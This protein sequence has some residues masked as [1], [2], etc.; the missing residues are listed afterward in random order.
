MKIIKKILSL[1]VVFALAFGAV[2]L[3]PSASYANALQDGAC[4]GINTVLQTPGAECGDDGTS[5]E[6]ISSTI[7]NVIN[8]FSL[9]VGA[10][11][12]IMIIYGGF[13]YITS[14]GSDD[15]TKSAKNTILYALVGLVI[16]LLAQTIVKFVF[17]KAV[18]FS[19][20]E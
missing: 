11:S 7:N 19:G 10:V 12:V 8:L 9:V 1:T 4:E 3:V 18:G 14:G 15:G 6:Q 17:G 16:V 20:N 5:N 2:S 13:K